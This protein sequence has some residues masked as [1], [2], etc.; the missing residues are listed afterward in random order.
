MFQGDFSE[1]LSTHAHRT[2]DQG[3][4]QSRIHQFHQLLAPDIPIRLRRVE[5]AFSAAEGF[6][7]GGGGELPGAADEDSV[8]GDCALEVVEKGFFLH[9]RLCLRR[10]QTV[11]EYLEEE[12]FRL[13]ECLV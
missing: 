13:V 10:I 4:Y 9:A 8:G 6:E 11:S 3:E 1:V 2:R 7:F 12:L 5:S